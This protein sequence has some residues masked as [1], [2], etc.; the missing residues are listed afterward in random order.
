[1]S[2]SLQARLRAAANRDT[3][4]RTHTGLVLLRAELARLDAQIADE[5]CASAALA[6]R[7]LLEAHRQDSGV[8]RRVVECA[9]MHALKSKGWRS[10]RDGGWI[11]PRGNKRPTLELAVEA[12]H[13][14]RRNAGR[15]PEQ[16]GHRP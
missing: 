9:Q 16:P 15:A 13:W 12:E 14:A 7:A 10:D 2:Y 11:G 8:Q 5:L 3:K 4:R 6:G 1:M